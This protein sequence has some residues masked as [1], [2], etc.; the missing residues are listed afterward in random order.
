VLASVLVVLEGMGM[1]RLAW[2]AL[3]LVPGVL[4]GLVAQGAMALTV[5]LA[6][7]DVHWSQLGC[8]L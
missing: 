5:L 3:G 2:E 7:W 8:G 1:A 6:R 4:T